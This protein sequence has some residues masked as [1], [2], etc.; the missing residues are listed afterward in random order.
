V[1]DVKN[2]TELEMIK[3]AL[4]AFGWNRRRAAQHLDISYRALLYKIQQHRL[5]PWAGSAPQE[6]FQAVRSSRHNAH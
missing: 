2:R 3:T 5:R 4:E 6:P 1:R